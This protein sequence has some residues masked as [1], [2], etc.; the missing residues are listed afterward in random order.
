MKHSEGKAQ[1]HD[2]LPDQFRKIYFLVTLNRPFCL[3]DARRKGDIERETER[4]AFSR[5][6]ADNGRAD[7][8]SDGQLGLRGP[9]QGEFV[10]ESLLVHRGQNA[11][12]FS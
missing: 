12:F 9:L 3:L 10:H 2:P 1:L 6:F 8:D 5:N 11:S 7:I 4:N